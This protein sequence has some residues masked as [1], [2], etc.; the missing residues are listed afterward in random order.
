L[1][2]CALIAD[3]STAPD[4]APVIATVTFSFTSAV[5]KY[6]EANMISAISPSGN[7]VLASVVP[8]RRRISTVKL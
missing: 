3:N 7:S 1:P 2:S 5:G 4:S 6:S 8:T